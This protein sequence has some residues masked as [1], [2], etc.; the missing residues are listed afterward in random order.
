[1]IKLTQTQARAVACKIRERLQKNHE[2]FRDQLEKNFK[3]SEE[4]KNKQREVHDFVV[5]AWQTRLKVGTML[6]VSTYYYGSSYLEKEEDVQ[7]AEDCIMRSIVRDYLNK[8]DTSKC[9][10]TEDKLVTDLIFESLTSEGIEEL[11]NK[12]IELYS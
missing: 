10:P 9:L 4:Y 6:K 3:D 8:H 2:N 5:Y 11:M 1:M 12:F 7:S